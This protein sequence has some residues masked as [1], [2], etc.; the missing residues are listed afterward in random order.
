MS[1]SM[2]TQLFFGIVIVAVISYF[3]WRTSPAGKRYIQKKKEEFEEEVRQLKLRFD[4][5]MVDSA[6]QEKMKIGM[7]TD[8]IL[9]FIGRP[10]EVRN[11]TLSAEG[12]SEEWCFNPILKDDGSNEIDS[13]G[14]YK[15]RKVVYIS[16]SLIEKIVEP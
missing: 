8:L 16:N 1:E 7:H 9:R 14:A 15:Y 13:S 2:I 4:S 10:E 12:R 11:K 6:I 5:D 3:I